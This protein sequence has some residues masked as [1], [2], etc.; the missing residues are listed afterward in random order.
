MKRFEWRT[1][2]CKRHSVRASDTIRTD[3]GLESV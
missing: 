2:G 3:E 1:R